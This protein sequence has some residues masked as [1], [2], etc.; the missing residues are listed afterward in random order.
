MVRTWL[1][2][3]LV[4]CALALTGC[5]DD[6]GVASG[7]DLS[8]RVTDLKTTLTDGGADATVTV[9]ASETD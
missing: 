2:I 9:D 5:E 1:A 3:L 4:P 7:G 6:D 8:A